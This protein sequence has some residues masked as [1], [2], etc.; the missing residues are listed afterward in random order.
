MALEDRMN[1]RELRQLLK[2]RNAELAKAYQKISDYEHFFRTLRELL[3]VEER[4]D[5]SD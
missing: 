4:P 1:A 2:S 3:N 5:P